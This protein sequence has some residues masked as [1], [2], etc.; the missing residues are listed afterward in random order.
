MNKA[1]LKASFLRR[2]DARRSKRP[3]PRPGSRLCVAVQQF[4]RQA[5]DYVGD[6][7]TLDL[8]SPQPDAVRDRFGSELRALPRK[9]T[10]L[11]M[12]EAVIEN[13]L[14]IRSTVRARRV[15]RQ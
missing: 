4:T 11:A 10:D 9:P 6:Q 15:I 13:L 8:R 14:R 5:A 3:G 12:F 2:A 7:T 1:H